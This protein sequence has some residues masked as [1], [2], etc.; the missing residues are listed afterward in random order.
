MFDERAPARQFGD[1]ISETD[2]P[3]KDGLFLDFKALLV[4]VKI[5]RSKLL[6]RR[7]LKNF[8]SE[9]SL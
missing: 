8:E 1:E 5:F 9:R 4:E 7:R 2:V 3:G 6:R